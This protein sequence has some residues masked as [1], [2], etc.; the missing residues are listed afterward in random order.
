MFVGSISAI[1]THSSYTS[2]LQLIDKI[3]GARW[4]TT[5]EEAHLATH[6]I[7]SDGKQQLKRTPK[8]MIAMNKTPNIVVL[9]WFIQSAKK[10]TV[11]SCE[12]Y[13]VVDKKAEEEYS[14][15]MKATVARIND[16]IES[17]RGVLTGKLVHVCKGVAG[18]QAPTENEL[19]CIVE[20]A[21]GRWLQNLRKLSTADA[22]DVLVIAS[23]DGQDGSQQMKVPAVAAAIKRGAKL[24]TAAWLFDTMMT[25]QLDEKK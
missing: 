17:G 21:G 11:L 6:V 19:R 5:T 2:D 12:K 16:H 8:L 15:N 14:F 25:Q 24:K 20:A 23:N 10:G 13:L 18:N 9:D 22:E 4:L 3:P 1:G 7:A